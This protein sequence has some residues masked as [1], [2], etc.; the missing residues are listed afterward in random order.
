MAKQDAIP[1]PGTADVS[2][3]KKVPKKPHYIPRPCGKPYNYKCF[4]CPFTCMA[5][6]H[7]YNHMKYSLCK[8]SVSVETRSKSLLGKS[9]SE[10]GADEMSRQ[11]KDKLCIDQ[12]PSQIAK[13]PNDSKS[14]CEHRI[15]PEL[16]SSQ[17]KMNEGFTNLTQCSE[18]M[19]R[20]ATAALLF[21][22][23][24][25][26]GHCRQGKAFKLLDTS[27]I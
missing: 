27:L 17:T 12:Q 13:V 21:S 14:I 19:S 26:R 20:V 1:S 5:K 16:A 10:D 3:N 11:Q 23:R 2:V 9:C 24:Q 6:S 25:G 18:A 7:L 15:D 8:Y 22:S 4:Q